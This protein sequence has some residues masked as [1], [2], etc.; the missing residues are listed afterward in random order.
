M[1]QTSRSQHVLRYGCQVSPL[2]SP[3]DARQQG[4]K[5]MPSMRQ[6]PIAY[7]RRIDDLSVWLH[8]RKGP[9]M[10]GSCRLRRGSRA[11]AWQGTVARPDALAGIPPG[12]ISH[13]RGKP[14]VGPRLFRSVR[15]RIKSPPRIRADG[16][17]RGSRAAF[18]EHPAH[19]KSSLR[20]FCRTVLRLEDCRYC[21]RAIR[22]RGLEA[23]AKGGN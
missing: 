12:V 13:Q 8:L 1:R 23:T 17:L 14:P 20:Q 4:R 18:F 3:T 7:E 2:G 6:G 16:V 19:F 21:V 22:T 5:G 10:A 15:R 9:P 11:S